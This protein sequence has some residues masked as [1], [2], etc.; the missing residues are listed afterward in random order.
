M[1]VSYQVVEDPLPLWKGHSN[2][3]NN[4]DEA[5]RGGGNHPWSLYLVSATPPGYGGHWFFT[6]VVVSSHHDDDDDNHHHHCHGW[7]LIHTT[8]WK[9]NNS[10]TTVMMKDLETSLRT[11]LARFQAVLP[12]TSSSSSSSRSHCHCRV[13]FHVDDTDITVEEEEEEEEATH[14]MDEEDQLWEEFAKQAEIH[15]AVE[16][17]FWEVS[18][19]ERLEEDGGA[20]N[21]ETM[22][23]VTTTTQE[24]EEEASNNTTNNH[25]S[26]KEDAIWDH[27]ARQA[28]IGQAVEEAFWKARETDHWE[29]EDGA[30]QVAAGMD[31]SLEEARGPAREA[32]LCQECTRQAAA[33][34]KAYYGKAR[35]DEIW[36]EC[37]RQAEMD[38]SVEEAHEEHW[39]WMH[40][41]YVEHVV[42]VA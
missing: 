4:D 9:D 35:E 30:R 14:W 8:T 23:P 22:D 42:V 7:E 20:G 21:A 36:D 1:A 31:R 13:G 27:C 15:S 40:P 29:E 24:E 10:N 32:E 19:G 3:N 18:E 39:Q 17:A 2:N 26:A 41:E 16:E 6:F 12:G 5:P 33:M 37:A 38:R 34:D 25:K 11:T 28:E